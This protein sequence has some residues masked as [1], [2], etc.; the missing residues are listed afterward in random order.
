MFCS[1]SNTKVEYM[2]EFR[3]FYSE[4]HLTVEMVDAIQKVHNTDSRHV[5]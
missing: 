2:V 1:V 3:V 5:L 4:N